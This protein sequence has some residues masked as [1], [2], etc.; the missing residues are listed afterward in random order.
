ML[1][2]GIV[3]SAEKRSES[4]RET[5]PQCVRSAAITSE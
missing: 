1:T 3:Q 4:G 5:E 2:V